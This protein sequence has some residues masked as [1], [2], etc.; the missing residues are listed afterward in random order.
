MHSEDKII[1]YFENEVG[2]GVPESSVQE[3]YT[4]QKTL[5]GRT[6]LAHNLRLIYF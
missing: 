5:I 4:L 6:E 2:S 1:E 3:T